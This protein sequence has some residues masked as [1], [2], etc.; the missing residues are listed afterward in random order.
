MAVTCPHCGATVWGPSCPACHQHVPQETLQDKLRR[1]KPA[2][3]AGDLETL[4]PVLSDPE[5]LEYS[6]LVATEVAPVRALE[7]LLERGARVDVP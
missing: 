6:L 1:L 2:L 7:H 4:S 5:L 3:A